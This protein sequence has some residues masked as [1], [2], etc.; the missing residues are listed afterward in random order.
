MK[1]E[2]TVSV[3]FMALASLCFA[4]VAVSS[5][6]SG[7]TVSSPV[8]VVATGSTDVYA[9]RI[10][11]DN[12]S[13]Y[14]TSGY[15][16]DTYVPMSGG[17]HYVVAQGWS[18]TG[19][20]YKTPFTINV[21]GTTT[22]SFTFSN[23]DQMTGWQ[24]CGA[25]A[26]INGNGPVGGYSSQQN[27]PSPSLDGRSMA[28]YLGGT[29]WA[30]ALWWKQLGPMASATHFVYDLYFYVAKPTLSQALEFDVNQS[31]NGRKYIFGTQ[32]AYGDGQWEVWDTAH[33][34]WVKTGIGCVPPVAYTWNHLVLEF[35]RLSNTQT[36]FVAVTLNGVK[37]YINRQFWTKAVSA[38][39]LN[40]AF[41]MDLKG[42]GAGYTVWLDRVN[43]NAW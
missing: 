22:S 38:Q 11:V 9:M 32:C 12:V 21:S 29:P 7:S 8:H 5:P 39:E 15:R 43:L 4:G 26:G 35:Q 20:I 24:S 16:N 41:Q 28:F 1:K 33:A 17:S 25:C 34:Y 19:A 36:S 23:I 2:L 30:D 37:R 40:V 10:Y 42:S 6:A 18:T 13:V 3:L 14:Y 31:V 27:V